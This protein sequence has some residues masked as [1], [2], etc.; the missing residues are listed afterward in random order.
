MSFSS[1]NLGTSFWQV[2][3]MCSW[4]LWW[5]IR[6]AFFFMRP[7]W[8]YGKSVSFL[9]SWIISQH[10][11]SPLT[12]IPSKV[13]MCGCGRW[14]MLGTPVLGILMETEDLRKHRDCC[15]YKERETWTVQ[16]ASYMTSNRKQLIKNWPLNY[17]H[18]IQHPHYGLHQHPRAA[19]I[20]DSEPA[21]QA[22]QS[23]GQWEEWWKP[24]IWT[25]LGGKLHPDVAPL[26]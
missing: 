18:H 3:P 2:R 8:D 10:S 11:S 13:F 24:G 26:P 17:H 4:G 6:F 20:R 22:R 9:S 7:V 15:S 19:G 5:A 14:V 16:R 25:M 1:D 21:V 12:H 23:W